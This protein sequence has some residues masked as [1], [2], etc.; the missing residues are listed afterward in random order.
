MN[1]N[2]IHAYLIMAHNNIRTLNILLEMIDDERNHIFIHIDQKSNIQFDE[3]YKVKHARLFPI[4]CRQKIYWGNYS[5]IKLELSLFE[6]AYS[7]GPYLYYHLLSGADLPIK[8][9]DYIHSFFKENNGK[10]FIGFAQGINNEQDCY[11]KIMRLHFLTQWKRTNN[12]FKKIIM[13]TIVKY[14]E[15]IINSVHKNKSSYYFKK[16]ANWVSITN[17]CCF[18]ILQHKDF[19]QQHFKYSLCGDEIFLQSIIFNSPFY[20]KCYSINDEYEGCMRAIDWT[21]GSPYEW[22][23]SD[24]DELINSNKLFARKFTDSNI[25]LIL[26]IK[27]Y[28]LKH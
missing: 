5:Q 11:R 20:Q 10:E 19:I 15:L 26:K 4:F 18:Y 21:R 2:E 13:S 17:D 12:I 7:N 9:Q 1:T 28:I 6:E 16:G 23:V 3:L 22:K 27:N 25:D 24:F 8:T 14:F